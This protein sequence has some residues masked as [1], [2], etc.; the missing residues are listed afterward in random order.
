MSHFSDRFHSLCDVAG[1]VAGRGRATEVSRYFNVGITSARNWLVED[2]CP[3]NQTLVKIIARLQKYGRL[4]K[5]YD[6]KQV[7]LWLEKGES[8]MANPFQ[9]PPEMPE[10]SSEL[11]RALK[12]HP[13]IKELL[14]QSEPGIGEKG[15]AY[16]VAL[17][18]SAL[19]E[20]LKSSTKA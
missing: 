12:K 2:I 19:S 11:I 9:E 13:A 6:D 1:F 10:A 4:D 16:L 3:R 7:L 18:E 5:S 14:E 8:Y 20:F 15:D 17:I